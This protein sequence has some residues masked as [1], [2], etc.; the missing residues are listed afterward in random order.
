MAIKDILDDATKMTEKREKLF[1]KEIKSTY[2]A[3]YNE[4][5]TSLNKYMAKMAD[6]KF[7]QS[8]MGKYKRLDSL[9]KELYNQLKTVESLEVTQ[10]K[11]YLKDAYEINYYNTGY[12]LEKESAVKL[13]FT[14]VDR[15]QVAAAIENPFM[16]GGLK[17]LKLDVRSRLRRS[18]AQS[19]AQGDGIQKASARIRKDLE[20]GANK[21][22]QIARTETT[23]VMADAREA[24][25][26]IATKKGINLKKQ[27]I[28]TNDSDTRDSHA[29]LNNE[30]QDTDKPFSNGMMKPGDP[31]GG[32]AEIVNCRCT[33][34]ALLPE[35]IEQIQHDKLRGYKSV[36]EWKKKR[37]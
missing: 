15:K 31:A 7:S 8:E 5:K 19:V 20:V 29:S 24:G 1:I 27:W 3:A 17:D 34:T 37:L 21:A 13:G 30:I 11:T 10:L 4:S 33:L 6:G 18:L 26:N 36:D 25:F 9:T 32:A 23:K 14:A 28:A 22:T 12:A 16:E 2:Q 35:S